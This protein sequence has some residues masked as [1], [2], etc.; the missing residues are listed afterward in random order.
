MDYNCKDTVTVY[1]KICKDRLK[2]SKQTSSPDASWPLN[3]MA[4]Y[5]FAMF[6]FTWTLLGQRTCQCLQCF[7]SRPRLF[8][9]SAGLFKTSIEL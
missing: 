2:H 9:Y 8:T 4:F 3:V 7:N 1:I 6:E 5:S